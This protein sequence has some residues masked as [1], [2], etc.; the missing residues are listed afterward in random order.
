[1]RETCLASFVLAA[2]SLR[3]SIR[4]TFQIN[5]GQ[6]NNTDGSDPLFIPSFNPATLTSATVCCRIHHPAIFANYSASRLLTESKRINHNI[7]SRS[8]RGY[9]IKLFDFW[10]DYME[11]FSPGSLGNVN[12]NKFSF[13]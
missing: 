5:R 8:G 2:V 6:A 1:M 4:D 3:A 11:Y 12:K 13:T 7:G 10:P 9:Y